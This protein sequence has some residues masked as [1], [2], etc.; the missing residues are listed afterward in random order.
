MTRRKQRRKKVRKGE[1]KEEQRMVVKGAKQG[2]GRREK[3]RTVGLE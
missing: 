1:K 3:N 2:K